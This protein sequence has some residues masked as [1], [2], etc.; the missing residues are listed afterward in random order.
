MKIKYIHF[1]AFAYFILNNITAQNKN[2]VISFSENIF[3][4]Q[5]LIGT[6][7]SSVRKAWWHN[8]LESSA[9]YSF[10]YSFIEKV[11]ASTIS[12]YYPIAPFRN[13]MPIAEAQNQLLIRDTTVNMSDM[14]MADHLATQGVSGNI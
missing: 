2:Q 13:I 9:Q 7:L 6:N 12:V 14:E 11:K 10:I 3:Y 8:R 5:Q 4:K 1:C